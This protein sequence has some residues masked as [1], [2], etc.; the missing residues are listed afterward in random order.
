MKSALDGIRVLDF[1][2]AIAGAYASAMLGDMGAEVI[3]VEPKMGDFARHWPPFLNGE[4]QLFIGWNRNKRSVVIDLSRSEGREL[5]L[6]MA[7]RADVLVENFRPGVAD[8]LGIGYG[9]VSRANPSIVYCSVSAFG[10]DGPYRDR[11]GFDPLLQAMGGVMAAQGAAPGGAGAPIFLIVAVSDY[12]TAMLSA[13]GVMTAL[14]LREKTG[15]GR[16][17]ETSLL[18]SVIAVQAERFLRTSVVPEG[19]GSVVPYQLFQ[20]R[21]DWVFLGVAHDGFWQKFC[22]VV[23]DAALAS[24]E[25]F[26]TNAKRVENKDALIEQLRRLFLERSA[27]EWLERLLDAGVPCAPVQSVQDLM[28]DPQVA[29]NDMVADLDHPKIGKMQAMGVPVKLSGLS[30]QPGG[31]APVLGQHT[32]EVL[33][34]YCSA[35]D[36][37][38]LEAEGVVYQD[39]LT[40]S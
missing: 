31:P 13:Y 6:T 32:R 33:A 22:R 38:R 19:L 17:V 25:R 24:D 20:A 9:D 26:T 28:D 4:S 30:R 39:P 18:N 3:K 23:G 15:A 1:G 34:E 36:A 10:E 14:Y 40:A 21:D 12:T 29:Y 16:R 11:P 37:Q 8:R 5:A 7:R 2:T 35:E 27:S